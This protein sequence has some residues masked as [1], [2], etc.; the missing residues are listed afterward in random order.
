MTLTPHQ[1]FVAIVVGSVTSDGGVSPDEAARLEQ[2]F[3]STRLFRPPAGEA[4]Q[5]VLADVMGRIQ[6]YGLDTMVVQAAKA[7][8]PGLRAPAFAMAVDLVL[9]DGDAAPRERAFIDTLRSCSRSRSRTRSG[10]WM[11]CC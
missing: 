6:R 4:L 5:A 2:V 10:S 9:A 8:P 7:L 3:A 1:A 11:C